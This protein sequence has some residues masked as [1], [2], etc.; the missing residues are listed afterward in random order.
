MKKSHVRATSTRIFM[1]IIILLL[2]SIS[3]VGFYFAQNWLIEVAAKN[4]VS[5]ITTVPIN[6]SASATKKIQDD[7][8]KYQPIA[9]KASNIFISAQDYQNRSLKDIKF[10]ASINGLSINSY[11]FGQT[12]ASE[13]KT[14][15]PSNGLGNKSVNISLGSPVE[16]TKLIKFIKQIETNAPKMQITEISISQNASPKGTVKVDLIKIEVYSR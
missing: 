14:N 9:D 7:I 6:K 5:N 12:N 3:A 11:D 10:Y 8:T 13:P 15:A 16:F 1:T 2:I 4:N